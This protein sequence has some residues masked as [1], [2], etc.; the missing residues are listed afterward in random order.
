MKQ[1]LAI[2]GAGELG[3]QIANLASQGTNYDIFGFFDDIIKIGI[4]VDKYKV[5]GNTKEILYSY[6]K[7]EFD[8]II[9]AIGYKYLK[10]RKRLYLELFERIPF[11]TIIHPTCIIDPSAIIGS[12]VVLYQGCIIDKNVII[13][14]NVLINIAVVVSHDSC[15]GAHS[16]IAPRVVFSGF[17]QIMECCFLGTGTIVVDNITVSSN[18]YI[19]AGAVII[20]NIIEEGVYV[21]NPAK[22][23]N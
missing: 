13:K 4:K 16:F 19:G 17:V 18:N 11:A 6:D 1:K 8:V 3:V 15:I 5:I 20:N 21:G 12:G 7:G 10:D 9:I 14:D 23:L 2:I 22:K